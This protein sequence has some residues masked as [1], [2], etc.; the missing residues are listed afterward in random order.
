METRNS[1]NLEALRIR[2][3]GISYLGIRLSLF[4]FFLAGGCGAPGEPTPP[5]PPVP[6]AVTDLSAQQAGDGV[7]LTFTMPPKTVAGERLTETPAIEILRGALKPDG[8][9]DAKSFRTVETI[10][11]ALVG[12]YRTADKV[13]VINRISPDEL[14]AYTG[15]ALAYRVRTRASRKRT[16]ADSNAVTVRVRPV[17]ER[18]TSI[19]AEVTEPAIEL[20]WSAP[21]RTSAGDPLPSISEYHVY[22]GEIDPAS[23]AAA[24]N[25]LSQVKWRSP[26]A[27]LVSSPTN[28]YRDATF[29][30][31]KTY[32]YTVRT[33]IPGN[34]S[35]LESSDSVPVIV[36]PRDTF[37]PAIPQGLVAA[38]L[39]AEP[40]APP[41]VDLSWSIN[42]ETDLVGYHVYRGE[43]Q[44]TPGQLVTPDLLL[45]P[46]YRDTSV[47]PGHRYWYSVT[48][49]DRSGNESAPSARIAAEVAQ[50]SS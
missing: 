45:S 28:S 41:E 16:S 2:R 21:T 33:V 42:T 18:I 10:P 29:D 50:P 40:N 22:R 30:F 43:Q 23:A 17:P 24:A 48:A 38:I 9:A 11:G 3:K 15:A 27:L 26:L 14:R 47:Q 5:S 34:G 39:S 6:V 13:Q 8:T 35:T 44:D 49:V 1:R 46:A 37:P 36:T 12:E 32:L 7:Q 4:V 20:S 19:H 25:D 31:G